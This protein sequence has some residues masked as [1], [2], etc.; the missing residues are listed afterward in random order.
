VRLVLRP[1][2][3]RVA[4]FWRSVTEGL[5]LQQLW[6]QFHREAGASYR[7]YARDL[8]RKISEQS[9]PRRYFRLVR[10]LFWAMLLKLSPARRRFLL[11]A[12]LMMVLGLEETR[13]GWSVLGSLALLGLLGVE[14]ADRVAMKRDL[15]IARDIQRWLVPQ[16]PPVVP[17]VDIAFT[18]RP[19]NTV[20]RV[21]YDAFRCPASAG[22]AGSKRLILVTCM[23]VRYAGS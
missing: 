9:G 5:S 11:I 3:A 23:I 7:I 15:E 21:Y 19:A 2:R 4:G 17:G 1:F 6:T 12:I 10:A 8:D 16:S 14:L 20:A 13:H 18:T 22:E